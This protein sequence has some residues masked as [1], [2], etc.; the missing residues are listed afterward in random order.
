MTLKWY[1]TMCV[2]HFSLRRYEP[3]QVQR[4]KSQPTHID[5]PKAETNITKKILI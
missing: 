3:N 1:N 5:T 4:V 2:V